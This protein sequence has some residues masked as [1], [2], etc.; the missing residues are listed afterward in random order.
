MQTF[1]V[2]P[3]PNGPGASPMTDYVKIEGA[4]ELDA[5]QRLMKIPLQRTARPDMYIRAFVHHNVTQGAP[6]KI[7]A[8]EAT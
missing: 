2:Q 5:A 7:Y 6:I 1:R 4:D 8:A 3:L